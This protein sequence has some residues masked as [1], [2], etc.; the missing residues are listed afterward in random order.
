VILFKNNNFFTFLRKT[1]NKI[2][3][4]NVQRC[5][6]FLYNMPFSLS[7]RSKINNIVSSEG[8]ND[9][10]II[11]LNYIISE[12]ENPIG[13]LRKNLMCTIE[14]P[15]LLM[16]S[17]DLLY[18][19][20]N[21]KNAFK[22]YE[23]IINILFHTG[24]ITIRKYNELKTQKEFYQKHQQKKILKEEYYQIYQISYKYIIIFFCFF[25]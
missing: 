6:T 14:N 8:C 4:L 13:S 21:L 2:G 19:Q 9:R 11:L 10:K 20:K 17:L 18:M 22:T 1:I 3:I 15:A 25:I 16:N 24:T 7:R 12:N 23:H 5:K